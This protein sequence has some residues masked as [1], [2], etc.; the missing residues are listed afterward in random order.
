LEDENYARE[1]M[2]LF[3]IGLYKL[4]IDGTKKLDSSGS[5]ISAYANSDIQNFARA[6]TGFYTI[7]PPRSNVEQSIWE[8]RNR[9]DPMAVKGM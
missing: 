1:V 6:W 3:S 9:I 8:W 7:Y 2:Q 4:N 5:P